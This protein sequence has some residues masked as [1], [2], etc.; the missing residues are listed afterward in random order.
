MVHRKHNQEHKKVDDKNVP[1]DVKRNHPPMILPGQKNPKHKEWVNTDLE[2]K[3]EEN[4]KNT[5][6]TRDE[7]TA[8]DENQENARVQS[9][10]FDVN[11]GKELKNL[12]TSL[13]DS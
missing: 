5:K 3:K 12:N 11:T 4:K 7:R 9:S 6:E 2:E 13:T 10:S 1:E 8:T